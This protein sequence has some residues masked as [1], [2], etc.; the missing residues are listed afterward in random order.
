MNT[1]MQEWIEWLK[2]YE[3]ELPLELQVKAKELLKKEKEHIIQSFDNGI[4]VGTYAV[5]KDGE[6]YYNQTYNQNK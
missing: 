6:D 4:Y 2:A 5:D 1:A 3:Y